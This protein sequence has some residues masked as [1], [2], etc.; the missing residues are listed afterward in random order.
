MAILFCSGRLNSTGWATQSSEEKITVFF[1]RA[2]KPSEDITRCLFLMDMKGL[3]VY[4]TGI[5]N[6]KEYKKQI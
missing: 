2:E 6:G 1:S 4:C 5:R 3:K